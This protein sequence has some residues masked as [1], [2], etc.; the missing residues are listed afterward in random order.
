MFKV[1]KRELRT[2]FSGIVPYLLGAFILVV[3]GLN[4]YHYCVNGTLSNFEYAINA[5]VWVFLVI[6]PLAALWIH[7]RLHAPATENVI[8]ETE[9][10]ASEKDSEKDAAAEKAKKKRAK[11]DLLAA[12]LQDQADAAFYQEEGISDKARIAGIYGASLVALLIPLVILLL[13]PLILSIYGKVYMP[14]VFAELIGFFFLGAA[15]NAVA[16]VFA[17]TQKNQIIS[18]L[19]TAAAL[20]FSYVLMNL[21]TSCVSAYS[22]MLFFTLLIALIA[23]FLYFVC[24]NGTLAL[25]CAV[26]LEIVQVLFFVLDQD[27]FESLAPVIIQHL[28][29]FERLYVFVGGI[30]DLRALVYFA[31]I[32]A[33]LLV[34]SMVGF[35]YEAPAKQDPEDE[36]DNEQSSKEKQPAFGGFPVVLPAVTFAVSLIITLCLHLFT[37]RALMLDVSGTELF[38]PGEQLTK[39]IDDL[40]KDVDI[41]W[42]VQNGMEDASTYCALSVYE[43]MNPHI[44]LIKCNPTAQY[45]FIQEHVVS[46]VFNNSLLF[47]C[48]DL[49]RFT[50]YND[51]YGYDNSRYK[52]INPEAYDL[53]FKIEDETDHAL[54]FFTGTEAQKVYYTTGHGEVAIADLFNSFLQ[55]DDIDLQSMDI[56][57]GVPEDASAVIV[58]A[59]ETDFSAKEADN[60]YAYLS[61]GGNMLLLTRVQETTLNEDGTLTTPHLNNLESIMLGYGAVEMP[62]LVLESSKTALDASHPYLLQPNV[63][64]HEATSE[65][66]AARMVPYLSYS[67]GLILSEVEGVTA[68]PLLLTSE[69]ACS[70][71]AGTQ[72]TTWEPE[73][74]DFVGS[75]PLAAAIESGDTHIVWLGSHSLLLEEVSDQSYGG[76]RRFLTGSMDYLTGGKTH[77]ELPGKLYN[78]GTLYSTT[79]ELVSS[80]LTMLL[81][82]VIPFIYL[83]L[84]IIPF[85]TAIA[86]KNRAAAE[87]AEKARQEEDAR[88]KAEEAE[89][90]A[91]REALRRQREE[92]TKAAIEAARKKKE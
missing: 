25:L 72:I 81:C 34:L 31:A 79:D 82:F 85:F 45:D 33:V 52:D 9:E 56:S 43:A 60:L 90:L 8:E 88:R 5:S 89:R 41:Y 4:T 10:S 78:Y 51:L 59:P 37:G 49:V 20:F 74:G 13:Y 19:F 69:E 83:L 30:F 35:G 17:S 27:G 71:A 61:Q 7:K 12:S 15:L 91:R 67:H 39:A 57:Q 26:V 21:S 48:E 84:G 76:N 62:G 86:R 42:I 22:G 18:L 46:D 36:S 14:V 24:K 44:T 80:R 73:P 55:R 54:E 68:T 3:V 16:L 53:V 64:E 75:I 1:L 23:A 6:C 38:T 2:L 92:A 66:I 87:A 32:A 63:Y 28:S 70:K 29:P 47:V 77:K 58:N 50:E 40:D 65:I 11:G